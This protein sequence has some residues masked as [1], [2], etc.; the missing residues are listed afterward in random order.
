MVPGL[1]ID[2]PADAPMTL[3]LAHGAGAPMDS[4]FMA[5]VAR[6]IVMFGHRVVR[7]EFP[8]MANRRTDGRRRPPD[9]QPVLLGAWR[10]VVAGLGAPERLVIGGKSM[11]GRMA[12]LLAAE[13]GVHGLVCLGYPFHPPGKPERPRVEHLRG[14]TVPTLIVQGTRDPFGNPSDVAGYALSST[15]EITW[16]DDGDHDLKPRKASGQTHDDA[17]NTATHAIGRFMK[18]RCR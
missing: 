11:G 12:S 13:G 10:E 6:R 14:L 7:F 2:G 9:R 4:P 1:L 5:D 16:I 17:L 15:V 18:S 3:V 8:Y